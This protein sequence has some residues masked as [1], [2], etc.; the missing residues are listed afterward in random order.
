MPGS[1]QNPLPGNGY[2]VAVGSAQD[3]IE[4][5]YRVL[6]STYGVDDTRF[7]W[8]EDHE[9]AVYRDDE[10]IAF[11][12]EEG[13]VYP[14]KESVILRPNWNDKDEVQHGSIILLTRVFTAP[15]PR[16]GTV[17]RVGESVDSLRRGM[18]V[19]LPRTGGVELGVRDRVLYS[20]KAEDIL[21]TVDAD[22]TVKPDCG[23]GPSA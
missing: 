11:L 21:G 12:T 13:E 3:E 18:L 10:V 9:Y 16:L 8:V 2:V 22:H 23:G 6:L 15:P 1:A 14:R 7:I 19:L 4:V 17:I 20:L 5:G